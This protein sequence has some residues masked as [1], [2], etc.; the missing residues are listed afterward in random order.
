MM[1]LELVFSGTEPRLSSEII[2]D[3]LGNQHKN[4]L[5]AIRKYKEALERFG[6]V[7]FQTRPFET[8]ARLQK[9]A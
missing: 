4:T 2:A 3:H 5:T 1:D 6:G 7:A 9:D 8:A